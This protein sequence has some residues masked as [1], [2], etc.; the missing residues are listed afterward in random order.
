MIR[1]EVKI[2]KRSTWTPKENHHSIETF[3]EAVNKNAESV[4]TGKSKKP[5]STVDKGET[6]AL[7]KLSERTDVLRANADKGGAVVI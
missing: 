4:I 3:I 5:K 2:K 6:G 7:N 1:N